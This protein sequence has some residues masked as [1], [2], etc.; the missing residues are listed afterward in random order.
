MYRRK[1][2]QTGSVSGGTWHQGEKTSAKSSM[3]QTGC[4]VAGEVTDSTLLSKGARVNSGAVVR[5]CLIGVVDN[6]IQC[7]INQCC[8]W[9]RNCSFCWTYSVRR[10]D[11]NRSFQ[12][13]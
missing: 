8:G 2:V 12:K 7:Q 4:I 11:L 3:I 13:G 9:S 10:Y 5:N 1:E 6:R